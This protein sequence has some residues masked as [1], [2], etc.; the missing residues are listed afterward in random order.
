MTECYVT[1]ILV[2]C[3][4]A[5]P[6]TPYS[7]HLS[8]LLHNR[9]PLITISNPPPTSVMP[10]PT[11]P[12]EVVVQRNEP[13]PSTPLLQ[14][15]ASRISRLRS[16]PTI[17]RLHH[18]AK[19]A[20][21]VH[22]LASLTPEFGHHWVP[23]DEPGTDM[24]LLQRR[25]D[26]TLCECKITITDYNQERVQINS[27]VTNDTLP[28]L[29]ARRRPLWSKIRWINV[30]GLSWD[31]IMTLAVHYELHLLAVEDLFHVPQRTKVDYYSDHIFVSLMLHTLQPET[32]ADPLPTTEP[33]TASP[34]PLPTESR[35]AP[36]SPSHRVNSTYT[37]TKYHEAM[38]KFRN[39]RSHVMLEQSFLFML[40]DGSHGGWGGRM[41]CRIWRHANT[42]IS[43]FQH[44]GRPVTEPIEQ[45]LRQP[46]T[47]LRCSIDV[48]L[49]MQAILDAIVDHTLPIVDSYREQI[50][51]L[52]ENILER[53][54]M[55]Y[56]RELHLITGEL[57]LLKRTLAPIQSLIHALR[58]HDERSPISPLGRTYMG[59]VLDHCTSTVES[60]DMMVTI[61]ENLINLVFNTI[62]YE[63]NE[64][65]RNLAIISIIFLPITFLAGFFGMN[66]TQFPE[67]DKGVNYFWKLCALVL[68]VTVVLF[69]A[70]YWSRLFKRTWRATKKAIG[71]NNV[72]GDVV[73]K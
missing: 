1:Y 48:S 68:A 51:E 25:F 58:G 71:W 30:D 12:T 26:S 46:K 70:S 52:E 14:N 6:F 24:S 73:I 62:S 28:A 22:R 37:N 23:G 3:L 29:L 53:P 45:R 15:Y 41:V 66:F 16:S 36:P 61:A 31:V 17:N 69:T 11:D 2:T 44:S 57:T 19:R 55:K 40:M 4:T 42:F 50:V 18:A 54:L 38:R 64:S 13:D 21:N 10:A 59:D 43:F 33:R 65:M 9:T 49:L 39:G 35:T 63:T 67:L 20:I 34:S 8:S 56:T 47:L 60:L 72:A 32:A 27:D 7:L 5:N